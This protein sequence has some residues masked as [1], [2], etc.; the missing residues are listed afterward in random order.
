MHGTW[1]P[2]C[3]EIFCRGCSTYVSQNAL[4]VKEAMANATEGYDEVNLD[5]LDVEL[6]CIEAEMSR[7]KDDVN[8]K[9]RKFDVADTIGKAL[10]LIIQV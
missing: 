1:T 5:T 10:T 8:A 6:N 3:G 7:N 2:S 9:D 4:D